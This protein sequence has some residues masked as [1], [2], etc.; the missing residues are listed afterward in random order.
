MIR[1][2]IDTNIIVSAL[3]QPLGAPAQ[4][5]LLAVSGAIQ[6]CVSGE[7]YA[8]YE[9]VIRRPRFRRDENVIAATL[10][11]I[12]EKSLWVKPTDTI[13]VCADPDDNIF[14]ECSQAAQAIYLV[15]GHHGWRNP[16]GEP[17]Q[18]IV[19]APR[20]QALVR[21]PVLGARCELIADPEIRPGLQLS[22]QGAWLFGFSDLRK[23]NG[24]LGLFSFKDRKVFYCAYGPK[25]RDSLTVAAN[26]NNPD[27]SKHRAAE[28]PG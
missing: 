27:D 1:V 17:S 5:F 20:P 3:L 16:T 11:T 13:R 19:E 24:W 4:V 18:R 8:E 7:V 2:V 6:L 9:E 10:N 12:R 23:M 22:K 28:A 25:N 26:Y 15:T 14:L 21:A